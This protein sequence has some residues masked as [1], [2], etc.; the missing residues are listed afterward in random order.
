MHI[1]FAA[2]SLREEPLPAS[3]HLRR[4]DKRLTTT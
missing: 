1:A 4:Y 2:L 3:A